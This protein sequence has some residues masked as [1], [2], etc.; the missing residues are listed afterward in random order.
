MKKAN[1][2]NKFQNKSEFKAEYQRRIIEKYGRSIEQAHKTEKYIVLGEMIRDFAGVNWKSSKEEIAKQEQKQMYYFSMEFLMGRLLTNNLMNL[3][4]YDIVKEGL[5]E[6]DVD[7]NELEDMESD[8]GLG[9][10]G[11]GRLAACFLD[12]L[13]SLNLAGHGNCIRYQYGLFA[14]KIVDNE[15]VELPDNWMKLGNVWEVRKP[16]HAV[17]VKFGGH[18]DMWMGE[19]GKAVVHH[20]PDMIVRA[21]PYDVPVVGYDT[22]LTNT[23]RLWSAEV[24]D[25]TVN[26]KHLSDY[27]HQVEEINLNVYPDDSTEA[28]KLLRL[29]QQYF[30]VCAG[31]HAMV[32]AHLRVYP[33]LDN[34]AQKCAVQLND[35]HPVLAIPELM[36]LLMDEYDYGW[37]E[38]W[39]ITTQTMAYTNHTV[40][41]EALEKW[42]IAYVQTLLPRIYLIIEEID[43]RF[44]YQVSHDYG[45]PELANELAVLKDGQ[46]HMAHLAIIGSHSVNGV[47][48][49]HTRI[50]IEDVMKNFY[51]IYP[52]KFNNKTNGIT[53]R[54]WLLYSNPQLSTL[55]DSYIGTGYHKD[56]AQLE[57]LM[58]HVD[59]TDLQ[60][61]F[62]NVKAQRKQILADY[63]L[64]QTGIQVNVNSI[65]DVQAKRLHAYK[66][67]LLN[68]MH[69]IHL[70]QRMK[71]DPQF[72]IYPRTFIF[73][74]K[75]APSYIFAKEV[76][77]LIHCVAERVNHDPHVSSMMKVV[78]LPNYGVSMAEVL[79]N[80]ADVSE[81]ISTAG[82][83]ASGTGNMKFMM[84]GAI[85]LGT[86]DGANVEIVERVGFEHAEIFGLRAD[87]VAVIRHD[88]MYN[89]W[90]KYNQSPILQ[91]VIG[92]FIDQTFSDDPN[93]FKTIYN[94]LMFKN[95]EYLCL[96]DFDAYVHAQRRVE[97][98][99]EDRR[100]WARMCLINIAKSGFFSSD[101]TIMQYAQE[102]WDIHPI[103]VK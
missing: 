51:T 45:H 54:R 99:Y 50:L 19:D 23:L 20:I 35:T 49:L 68:V 100:A 76:I 102:V 74:A 17:N 32:K 77:K 46:V 90:D 29:K 43:H 30:F 81:Q 60:D 48:A 26:A 88:N 36:R 10:G 13:A 97:R 78:F 40:L 98:R 27:V 9:N 22:K 63:I 92:S 103:V 58:H 53:H 57:Q 84:N 7:I 41:S 5:A 14:Q 33:N 25:E 34:L 8:A 24:A 73:A 38:A 42:P 86:M 69:I 83:E 55:L 18:V 2:E 47:A 39:E 85:T 3:G 11:L 93:A 12:S 64:K 16:K 15:Q 72:R 52:H 31:L 66:R 70:Y 59:E 75:A 67:Q 44:R 37:D 89:A 21:V 56:P 6:L 4:I 96:A 61:A 80:A 94:E 87:D 62:L 95:D 28:G 101:R 91:K 1:A 79:Q 71:E 82:K 65:F